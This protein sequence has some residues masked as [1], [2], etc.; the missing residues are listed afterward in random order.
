MQ[1]QERNHDESTQQG[2]VATDEPQSQVETPPLLEE[3]IVEGSNSPSSIEQGNNNVHGASL[4]KGRDV[5]LR[6]L[7]FRKV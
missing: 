2:A 3:I 6:D 1:S 7:P 4:R 5:Y